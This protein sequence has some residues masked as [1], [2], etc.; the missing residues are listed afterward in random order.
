MNG[1][2][3]TPEQLGFA[4]RVSKALSNV[5]EDRRSLLEYIVESML[6]AASVA[7]QLPPT[8]KR[9]GA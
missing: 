6:I 9:P 8:T 7:T 5:P 1:T 2:T 3:H 4:E